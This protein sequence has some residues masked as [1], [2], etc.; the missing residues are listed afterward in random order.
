MTLTTDSTTPNK[1]PVSNA[2]AEFARRCVAE[3]K[4]ARLK[5]KQA[6][7]SAHWQEVVAASSAMKAEQGKGRRVAML[8]E[9]EQREK[10]PQPKSRQHE[11]RGPQYSEDA[12][13][14]WEAMREFCADHP[15]L[16]RS[17]EAEFIESLAEWRGRPT[18]RQLA[19]LC[20]IHARLRR[21]TA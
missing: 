12:C 2:E 4:F 11:Q 21:Q 19:C 20:A 14:D 6:Q 16:L 7:R 1:S 13:D 9:R 15:E 17:R 18:E 10:T 3:E 5:E 8:R